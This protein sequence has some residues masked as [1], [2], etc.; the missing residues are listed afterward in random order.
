MRNFILSLIIFIST[1]S[2]NSLSFPF[3]SDELSNQNSI[4][5]TSSYL[6]RANKTLQRFPCLITH[7]CSWQRPTDEEPELTE[8]EELQLDYELPLKCSYVPVGVLGFYLWFTDFIMLLTSVIIACY[9]DMRKVEYKN[10]NLNILRKIG[11]TLLFIYSSFLVGQYAAIF[12]YDCPTTRYSKDNAIFCLV[13]YSLSALAGIIL[14][15]DFSPFT[16]IST[17]ISIV[18][19]LVSGF[20]KVPPSFNYY[21]KDGVTNDNDYEQIEIPLLISSLIWGTLYG[22]LLITIVVRFV[23][24]TIKEIAEEPRFVFILLIVFGLMANNF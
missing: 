4:N 15:I 18:L 24:A 10:S 12:A 13:N 2:S 7:T 22:I 6:D 3:A 17:S 23:K 11:A 21:I 14:F 5:L 9:H 20:M 16:K 8:F 1:L 19:V